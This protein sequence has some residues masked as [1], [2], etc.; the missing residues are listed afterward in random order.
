MNKEVEDAIKRFEAVHLHKDKDELSRL[1]N[2]SYHLKL[3]QSERDQITQGFFRKTMYQGSQDDSSVYVGTDK[4][5]AD[6]EVVTHFSG[7]PYKGKRTD[8]KATESSVATT[9]L[10]TIKAEQQAF[11]KSVIPFLDRMV[12]TLQ[13]C[14]VF[15]NEIEELAAKL[16][17]FKDSPHDSYLLSCVLD[18]VLYYSRQ[19]TAILNRE[20]KFK[21]LS[22]RLE[23]LF[24][25]FLDPRNYD[26]EPQEHI[27][28]LREEITDTLIKIFHFRDSS[29]GFDPGMPE[30]Q[31]D[32]GGDAFQKMA[33]SGDTCYHRIQDHTLRHIEEGFQIC[34]NA[35]NQAFG[36]KKELR[37][38]ESS[39]PSSKTVLQSIGGLPQMERRRLKENK[40]NLEFLPIGYD[41]NMLN[42]TTPKR[43]VQKGPSNN[44]TD[45][46]PRANDEND[47]L[48]QFI[49]EQA[50]SR[51]RK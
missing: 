44:D 38:Y 13:M 47:S 23:Y 14:S 4:Y 25:I 36:D 19:T 43:Q 32:R 21:E 5:E 16:E 34:A 28:Y 7:S 20:L 46:T 29:R 2:E 18:D 10:T 42:A 39:I 9:A 1:L 37:P 48:Q 35:M 31:L 17:R 8:S 45:F 27:E 40:D 15:T 26:M 49:Q 11:K 41:E 3:A 24:S 33:K 12:D 22:Q 6:L 30:S 50:A 51:P